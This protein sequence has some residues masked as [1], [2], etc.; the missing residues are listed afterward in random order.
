MIARNNAIVNL[1]TSQRLAGLTLGENSRV[2]LTAVGTQVLRVTASASTRCGMDL[3]TH[4]MIVQSTAA[5]RTGVLIISARDPHGRNAATGTAADHQHG[6]RRRF[7]T[8]HG[9]AAIIND[10]GDGSVVRTESVGWG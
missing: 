7:H 10:R 5:G 4:S 8:Q 3:G 1:P 9:L 2:N 6:G